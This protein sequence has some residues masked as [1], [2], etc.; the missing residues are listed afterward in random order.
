M[1]E[2]PRSISPNELSAI[3]MILENSPKRDQLLEKLATCE[4]VELNEFGSIIEFVYPG[5]NRND[6]GQMPV[7]REALI[8]DITGSVMEVILYW[9]EDFVLRELEFVRTD[10]SAFSTPDWNTFRIK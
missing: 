9:D 7:G 8:N 6:F 2:E 4:V 1:T 10:D 3:S 5:Q